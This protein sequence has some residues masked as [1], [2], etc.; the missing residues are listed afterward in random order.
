MTRCSTW[1]P[2]W[3]RRSRSRLRRTDLQGDLRRGRI[4][5][6]P[7]PD[8][9]PEAPRRA[10]PYPAARG[11]ARRL[12]MEITLGPSVGALV[13][14]IHIAIGMLWVGGLVWFTFAGARAVKDRHAA[15]GRRLLRARPACAPRGPPR[16]EV[17]D[18]RRFHPRH[19]RAR[20][21]PPR[22]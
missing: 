1:P 22:R 20:R 18:D 2:S 8:P 7:V 10:A 11:T 13:R 21:E 4:R 5:A 19:G 3:P 14:W 9:R 16:D 6:D 12:S 15:H 17:R